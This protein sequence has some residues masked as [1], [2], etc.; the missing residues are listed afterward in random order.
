HPK[1]IHQK[2][3]RHRGKPGKFEMRHLHQ[4]LFQGSIAGARNA[5]QPKRP[6]FPSAQKQHFPPQPS[7]SGPLAQG[8]ARQ[9]I[10]RGKHHPRPGRTPGQQGKIPR[11]NHRPS[12][13]RQ[14]DAADGQGDFGSGTFPQRRKGFRFF[15]VVVPSPFTGRIGSSSPEDEA[16]EEP[17]TT[18][19]PPFS[20]QRRTA[21]WRDFPREPTSMPLITNTSK[22]D[23]PRSLFGISSALNPSTRIS[24]C[25][26][27]TPNQLLNRE[28]SS[29]ESLNTPM[30]ISVPATVPPSFFRTATPPPV[31][32]SISATGNANSLDNKRVTSL[33]VPPASFTRSPA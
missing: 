2:K 9:I 7:D 8:T 3:R 23:K 29:G 17:A 28:D 4:G 16:E 18:S 24:E 21:L 12:P 10:R 19:R 26:A 20:T 31:R 33:E 1:R 22:P 30:S 13:V 32:N 15:S 14:P 5:L 11:G 25:P 6:S 27:D